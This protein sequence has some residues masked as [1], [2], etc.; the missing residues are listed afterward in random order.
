MMTTTTSAV[1]FPLR[2]CLQVHN[3]LRPQTF[4]CRRPQLSACHQ[5]FSRPLPRM[6]TARLLAS[7]QSTARCVFV[8]TTVSRVSEKMTATGATPGAPSCLVRQAD[9]PLSFLTFTLIGNRLPN[10]WNSRTVVLSGPGLRSDQRSR[11]Q[12][13]EL[14]VLSWNLGP[15]GSDP[16]FWLLTL[17]ARGM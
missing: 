2:G 1:V 3:L 17:I 14:Q 10:S 15:R 7:T 16:C 13:D 9:T 11:R 5:V 6:P 8:L 4:V 12:T